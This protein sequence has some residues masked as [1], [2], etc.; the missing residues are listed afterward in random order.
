[1]VFYLLIQFPFNI[2]VF[3]GK[4]VK[5]RESTVL[6]RWYIYVSRSCKQYTE[7]PKGGQDWVIFSLFISNSNTPW[8]LL[9]CTC[10]CIPPPP[11]LPGTAPT[12]W[13]R[14]TA[15][16]LTCV[17]DKIP[18]TGMHAAKAP[19]M[20]PMRILSHLS[21][22]TSIPAQIPQAYLFPPQRSFR[23]LTDKKTQKMQKQRMDFCGNIWLLGHSFHLDI[24][25]A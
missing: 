10:H 15:G 8:F 16:L 24:F 7:W 5:L 22:E 4:N 17:C 3:K 20:W 13:V 6:Y 21:S 14:C 25:P 18:C 2:S 12:T 19:W 23:F 1:M 11:G 9:L